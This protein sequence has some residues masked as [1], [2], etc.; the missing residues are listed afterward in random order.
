MSAAKKLIDTL[1]ADVKGSHQ[2]LDPTYL[3]L[4]EV[5]PLQTITSKTH[6][7][8]ALQVVEKL[9]SYIN[10]EQPDDK[11]VEVYLKTLMELVGDYERT[12]FKTGTVTGA[13]MLAY[14]MDLQGLNQIDLSKEL[15][16][17][18]VVSKILKGERELN[19]RQ[20]KALAKRFK[21]SPVVFI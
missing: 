20:I 2:K 3:K 15:G 4:I 12:H 14:I 5:F 11:G 13:E 10:D 8:L 6:H 9:I 19:L 7:E 16:G 21:V 1:K 17:Q 18:P